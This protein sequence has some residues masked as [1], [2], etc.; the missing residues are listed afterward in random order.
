[1]SQEESEG[2]DNDPGPLPRAP[3]RHIDYGASPNDASYSPWSSYSASPSLMGATSQ[4]STPFYTPL[5]SVNASPYVQAS[6]WSN[7]SASPAFMVTTSQQASPEYMPLGSVGASPYTNWSASPGM[8]ITTSQQASPAVP[9]NYRLE[10]LPRNPATFATSHLGLHTGPSSANPLSPRPVSKPLPGLTVLDESPVLSLHENGVEGFNLLDTNYLVPDRQI[11]HL[12]NVFLNGSSHVNNLPQSILQRIFDFY[13]E[14]LRRD[15]SRSPFATPETLLQVCRHW[16]CTAECYESIWAK[17]YITLVN[18]HDVNKWM[19]RIRRYCVRARF[20]TDISIQGQQYIVSPKSKCGFDDNHHFNG[21]V[22][23][24]LGGV[25]L[26]MTELNGVVSRCRYRSFRL[27]MPP[28]FVTFMSHLNGN[29]RALANSL[30]NTIFNLDLRFLES[31]ELEHVGWTR[32][33]RPTFNY[34]QIPPIFQTR[35]NSLKT[36]LLSDCFLPRLP[37]LGKAH[38]VHLEDCFQWDFQQEEWVPVGQ[39]KHSNDIIEAEMWAD[40]QTLTIGPL[41]TRII[42]LCLPSLH[43]LELITRW[44]DG[45]TALSAISNLSLESLHRLVIL[46]L[47]F[48]Y[49]Q[50]REP[51]NILKDAIAA[52]FANAKKIQVIE[53]PSTVLFAILWFLFEQSS[54]SLPFI[55]KPTYLTLFQLQSEPKADYGHDKNMYPFSTGGRKRVC[56]LQISLT[57][58]ES[59]EQLN[60]IAIQH[61]GH[62]LGSRQN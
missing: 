62:S 60:Y 1:M 61:F 39:L 51:T 47:S 55:N 43:T 23:A 34:S 45:S 37:D 56:T 32:S 14:N 28:N 38:E 49:A 20:L 17:V 44:D 19:A 18:A 10:A 29:A 58:N 2:Y 42:P 57:G 30:L 4:K 25:A 5:G 15:T 41:T 16:K 11:G 27:S 46:D 3:Q 26:L 48:P 40:L 54:S 59:A 33:T 12:F 31:L 24:Y 35:S 53:A 6:P 8:M 52:L 7:Y 50:L 21:G 9:F 22:L 36:I 13:A